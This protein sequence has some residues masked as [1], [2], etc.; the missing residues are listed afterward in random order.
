[1]NHLRLHPVLGQPSGELLRYDNTAVLAAGAAH[2]DRDISLAFA[3]V[4]LARICNTSA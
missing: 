3:T 4:A 1:V 2:R